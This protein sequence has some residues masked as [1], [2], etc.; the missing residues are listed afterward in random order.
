MFTSHQ[1]QERDQE[2]DPP[3]ILDGMRDEENDPQH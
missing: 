3:D 2:E 1:P